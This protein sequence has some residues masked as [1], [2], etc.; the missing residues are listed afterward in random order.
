MN[1]T[2]V[3][4]LKANLTTIWS[5]KNL[6]NTFCVMRAWQEEGSRYDEGSGTDLAVI[7]KLERSAACLFPLRY[8]IQM[9]LTVWSVRQTGSR[10]AECGKVESKMIWSGTAGLGKIGSETKG[11]GPPVPGTIRSGTTDLKRT[12]LD[13]LLMLLV[14]YSTY[15]HDS[16][17]CKVSFKSIRSRDPRNFSLIHSYL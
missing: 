4:K 6:Q 16:P 9:K 15:L 13:H 11:R 1:V 10:R 14:V 3:I 2:S 7:Q 5:L 12:W 17:C 8:A